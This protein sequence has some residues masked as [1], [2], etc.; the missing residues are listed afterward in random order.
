MPCT[1]LSEVKLAT[2]RL[3][4]QPKE[5]Q[6]NSIPAQTQEEHLPQTQGDHLPQV[7]K[8]QSLEKNRGKVPPSWLL[9]HTTVN[10]SKIQ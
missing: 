2:F 6:I 10:R 7:I 3:V 5:N 8:D 9:L 1:G 4:L